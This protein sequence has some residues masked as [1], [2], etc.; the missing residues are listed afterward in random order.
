VEVDL[1]GRS[2]VYE[3]VAERP[4]LKAMNDLHL[5]RAGKLWT[6]MADIY[7]AALGFLA[8]TGLFVLVGKQGI[9]GRGAWLTGIGIIIPVMLGVIFL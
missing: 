5:N 6:W 8:I 7:A 3:K 1:K 4:F 2:A 9:T